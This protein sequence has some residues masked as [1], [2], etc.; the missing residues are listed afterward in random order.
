M[1][2]GENGAAQ[3]VRVR[4]L[5]PVLVDGA[6]VAGLLPRRLIAALA[7][8]SPL[9]A[10]S[11]RLIDDVW[12]DDPPD[13]PRAALQTLVSRVR[14][15]LGADAIASGPAGYRLTIGT[16]L[17]V[18]RNATQPSDLEHAL[19]LWHGDPGDDLG[20]APVADRL[21]V[22]A[23][24]LRGSILRA[25]ARSLLDD[26]RVDEA[27]AALTPLVDASPLDEES[28]VLLMRAHTAAG[29]RV[30]ALAVFARLRGALSETLGTTPGSDA[31]ELNTQLLRD[32]SPQRRRIGVRSRRTPLV[33]RD[34]DIAAVEAA[35]ASHRLTTIL[36][37]GGLGKTSLAAEVAGRSTA[38]VTVLVELAPA[39]NPDDVMLTIATTLGIRTVS[40]TTRLSDPLVR[41]DLRSRVITMLAERDTLLVLDN[42]EHLVATI[43]GITDDLLAAVASLRIVATSRSPLAI[44]G[45]Q[46]F[47]LRPLAITDAAG[48]GP[49]VTLF[50]ERARAV[51]PNAELD[52]ATVA[53][54]CESLD[55]LPLAI[56][57]AAARVRSMSL[58]DIERRL[59]DRFAL[60]TAVDRSAPE[61]HRTLF[62]VIDWSWKLLDAHQRRV[63]RRLAL[64]ADGFT[65]DAAAIVAGDG[66]DVLDD[67]DAL[68]MQSLVQVSDEN[69]TA[70]YRL[71]ETVSEF[72]RDRLDDAGERAQ[73]E[74][75]H[76]A[77]AT[78]LALRI[79]GNT[80]G[81]RQVE[82][83]RIARAERENLIAT[84]RHAIT[85][86]RS[87]DVYALFG[88]LS[89]LWMMRG[90]HEEIMA[91]GADVL[92]ASSPREIPAHIA[93]AAGFGLALIAVVSGLAGMRHATY[94]ALSR[95]RRLTR[96]GSI[97]DA[98]TLIVTELFSWRIPDSHEAI[99]AVLGRVDEL[100]ASRDDMTSAC[101]AMLGANVLENIGEC[102]RAI[103]L[104]RTASARAARLE[105]PWLMG[106]AAL[107]LA[108]LYGET[109]RIEQ[110]ARWATAARKHLALIDSNQD[111][112][113]TEWVLTLARI[114]AGDAG[115]HELLAVRDD[116]VSPETSSM[117][118]SLHA[119]I[120]LAAGDAAGARAVFEECLTMLR[121]VG[122]RSASWSL[123]VQAAL[124]ATL[125]SI[126]G[127]G[128]D[129][130]RE[131]ARLA[132]RIRVMRRV[133]RWGV[134]QPVVGAGIVALGS[135]A[136]GRSATANVGLQL[137]ALAEAMSYRRDFSVLN[138]ESILSRAAEACGADAVATARADAAGLRPL[139]RVERATELLDDLARAR[140]RVTSST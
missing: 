49:A 133:R 74:E 72:A 47:V 66:S 3:S 41:T 20:D 28:A 132:T 27:T 120:A 139:D 11:Q 62:A 102:D 89:A 82:T 131:V 23:D 8:A 12:G 121:S 116:S 13:R 61:R 38:P 69:G 134:D 77:W 76:F 101:A 97:T 21:T 40:S 113:Q 117:L 59:R 24:A 70:R 95:V 96:A 34:D 42:C 29:R 4:V 105:D 22:Q 46:V 104:A 79:F 52:R 123:L 68:V 5:G 138:L 45:E 103:E 130:E 125:Q 88:A 7:L 81:P 100:T 140:R 124:V 56:E 16:D 86:R 129:L 31:V 35:V 136:L 57:L 25:R 83:M 80:I 43:A 71:L 107:L 128:D 84:L 110:C 98:R 118:L 48:A 53:R 64:F 114:R 108:Q 54:I 78:D 94:P 67:L 17:D 51:R 106:Y 63:M 36:G 18:A 33:G 137:V 91:F 19:A 39:T 9:V 75:R 99:D 50:L 44:E 119:E 58:D 122:A 26:A 73:I 14:R 30:D 126:E 87:D 15:L 135:F 55:G 93:D 1:G 112:E 127:A 32:D 90:E 10:S 109:G 2:E 115:P 65:A 111:A 92:A 6:P 37:V 85:G 60:L